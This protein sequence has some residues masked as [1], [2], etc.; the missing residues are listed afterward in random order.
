MKKLWSVSIIFS[1][2]CGCHIFLIDYNQVQ[3]IHHNNAVLSFSQGSSSM[4]PQIRSSLVLVIPNCD[5]LFARISI[6]IF[7]AAPHAICWI[8]Q[9]LSRDSAFAPPDDA[10]LT[11]DT[12][13][14][15][16]SIQRLP[17]LHLWFILYLSTQCSRWIS[18]ATHSQQMFHPGWLCLW[19]AHN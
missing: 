2:C 13:E 3:V 15:C 12:L 8:F 6:A 4:A 19:L 11:T 17:M 1:S 10:N 16:L 9:D 5:W 7:P 14:T 18:M